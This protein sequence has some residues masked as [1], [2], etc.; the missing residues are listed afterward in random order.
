M[1]ILWNS[2]F[3]I[4]NIYLIFAHSYMISIIPIYYKGLVKTTISL[5]DGIEKLTTT[6]V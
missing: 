1:I 5:V 6:P 4:A 2:R 3:H